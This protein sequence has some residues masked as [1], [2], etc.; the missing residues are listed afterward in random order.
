VHETLAAVPQVV[1]LAPDADQQ[2]A[3]VEDKHGVP[4]LQV[5][6]T[7]IETYV[8]HPRTDA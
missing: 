5:A 8:E 6:Q 4:V 2:A 1:Q 3:P 7:Q